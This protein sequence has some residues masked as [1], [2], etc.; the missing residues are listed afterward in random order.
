MSIP[1]H[2]TALANHKGAAILHAGGMLIPVK[3]MDIE[4]EESIYAGSKTTF[5]GLVVDANSLSTT[6][7]VKSVKAAAN[8]LYGAQ[9][10]RDVYQPSTRYNDPTPAELRTVEPVSKTGLPQV[11]AYVDLFAKHAEAHAAHM[12]CVIKKTCYD[13]ERVIFNDPA[14]IVFWKNG[15]KTI[16][17]SRNAEMY[18]METDLALCFTLRRLGIAKVVFDKPTTTATWEDGTDTVVKCQEGDVWS[19][20]TGLFTVITK[21][22]LGNNGNFNEVFKKHIPSYRYFLKEEN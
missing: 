13:I 14:T 22:T 9:A 11:D 8:S 10:L 17:V 20:E 16:V 19:K 4:H 2:V 21:K 15:D 7:L 12:P 3:I 5:K 18:D 6:E 1:K